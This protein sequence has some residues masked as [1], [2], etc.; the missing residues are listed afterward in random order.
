[1]DVENVKKFCTSLPGATA[2]LLAPPVNVLSYRIESKRF[3][4]FKTSEP[5]Q[6]RFSVR[7]SAERFVELT[8]MPGVKPAKYMGRYYWVTI[9]D[10]GAFDPAYLVELIRSSYER[11]LNALPKRQRALYQP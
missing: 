5:E 2:I 6:W 3:A 8:D 9:V 10:V 1:M 4:Y 7:V 11:A